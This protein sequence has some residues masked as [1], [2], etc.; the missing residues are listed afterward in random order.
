MRLPLALLSL[1]TPLAAGCS[2]EQART[3]TFEVLEQRRYQQ[4]LEQLDSLHCDRQ[5]QSY[6][7]YKTE[8]ER[9]IQA[10]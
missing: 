10:Q 5:R 1:L 4:C 8:R 7:E 3:A 9:H 2:T 6:K